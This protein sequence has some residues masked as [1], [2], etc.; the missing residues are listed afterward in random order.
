MHTGPRCYAV[1]ADTGADRH[2]PAL[3]GDRAGRVL[4]G[5]VVVHRDGGGLRAFRVSGR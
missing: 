1:D 5:D 4:A 2:T 3:S